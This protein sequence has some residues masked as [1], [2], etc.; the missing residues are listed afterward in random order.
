M[1][2]T[3][4]YLGTDAFILGPDEDINLLKA[5]LLTAARGMT[6]FIDFTTADNHAVSALITPHTHVVLDVFHVSS[7]AE[8]AWDAPVNMLDWSDD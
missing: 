2:T 4:L 1:H 3:R 8:G 6:A 5:A 7:E